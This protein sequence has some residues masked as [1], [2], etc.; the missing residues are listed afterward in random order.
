MRNI[1]EQSAES[2]EQF[3]L[4]DSEHVK[5]RMHLRD[6][7]CLSSDEHLQQ[8]LQERKVVQNE[9]DQMCNQFLP[10]YESSPVQF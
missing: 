5:H 3:S 4:A 2:Y 7:L 6:E 1:L 10:I 9:V 8:F